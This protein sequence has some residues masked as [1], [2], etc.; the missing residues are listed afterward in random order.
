MDKTI[1]SVS[2]LAQVI[3]GMSFNKE[4]MELAAS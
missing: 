3:A 4:V 2:M 1:T